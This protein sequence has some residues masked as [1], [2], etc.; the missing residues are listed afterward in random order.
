[1]SNEAMLGIY[2]IGCTSRTPWKRAEELYTTG[3][4]KTFIIEYC[5]YID[6]YQGL[7]RLTHNRLY[8]Y[9]FNKEFFKLDL[10]NCIL[11]LKHAAISI[12]SYKEKYRN[13]HLRSQ[14]EGREA[15]YL[16]EKEAEERKRNEELAAQEARKLRE[17]RVREILK[18]RE[19]EN[20]QV[21]CLAFFVCCG[22][23]I[24][25]SL[26]LGNLWAGAFSL[27]LG[28]FLYFIIVT[29]SK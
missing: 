21:G 18:K 11:E 12:S 5:I 15:I 23:G 22:I 8:K 27:G 24:P 25:L 16:R 20:K 4:P 10:K 9:N 29:Y 17:K 14:V 28:I 1:M 19:D 13:Q 2:K 7:E 26:G 6:D 3:V